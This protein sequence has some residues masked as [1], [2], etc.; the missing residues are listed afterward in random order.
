MRMMLRTLPCLLVALTILNHCGKH[1]SS[2]ELDEF[3]RA[4]QLVLD[5]RYDEALPALD[6]FLQRYGSGK[7]AS[8]AQFFRGKVRIGQGRYVEARREFEQTMRDFPSSDEAQKARYKIAMIDMVQGRRAEALRAFQQ[9]A[10]D[11]DGPLAPEARM[12]VEFL[13]AP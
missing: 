3:L 4:R 13:A 7:Y 9:L 8:R 5:G 11:P 6:A 1:G 12:M 2:A 10:E